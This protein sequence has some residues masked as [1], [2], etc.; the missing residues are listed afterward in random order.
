MTDRT[1]AIGTASLRLCS[2]RRPASHR[3]R[4]VRGECRR[5]TARRWLGAGLVLVSTA[6]L[7][8]AESPT[9]RITY[10]DGRSI[11]GRV[12]AETSDAIRLSVKGG[13]IRIPRSRIAQIALLATSQMRDATTGGAWRLFP[14]LGAEARVPY[15]W[16]VL[17]R[18]PVHA[19][20]TGRFVGD[21]GDRAVL[22]SPEAEGEREAPLPRLIIVRGDVVPETEPSRGGALGQAQRMVEIVAGG[23][24]D[25]RVARQPHVTRLSGTPAARYALDLPDPAHAGERLLQESTVVIKPDRLYTVDAMMRPAQVARWQAAV[26]AV[27]ESVR[28]LT[29]PEHFPLQKSWVVDQ[30]E[31]LSDAEQKAVRAAIERL[32]IAGG[33]ECAVVTVPTIRPYR[34]AE[35]YAADLLHFWRVG[36]E[37]PKG[38][39]LLLVPQDGQ[40]PVLQASFGAEVLLPPATG[41]M[42]VVERLLPV[43]EPGRIGGGLLETIAAIEQRLT[44]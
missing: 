27:A 10:T 28:I 42:I 9:H 43:L 31:V 7:V 1:D 14:S 38:G 29:S 30:A 4:S 11:E 20:P 16:H 41:Q 5:R 8:G 40:L 44:P 39:L 26:R 17:E 36:A 6:A 24:A 3:V 19:L 37:R 32:E 13:E 23:N 25:V 33:V 35:V 18:L 2:G 12:T 21:D 22:I 15:G 34:Q